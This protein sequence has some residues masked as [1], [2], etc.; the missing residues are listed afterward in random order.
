MCECGNIC[1]VSRSCFGYTRSCGCY[2][3]E[4]RDRPKLKSGAEALHY[5]D[6]R[7]KEKLYNVWQTMKART[8]NPNNKSYKDYGKRGIV[9]CVEWLDYAVFRDW[10]NR[11]GY[12][13]K[14]TIERKDVNGNYEPS[15]CCFIPRRKQHYNKTNTVFVEY[16]GEIKSLSEW[17]DIL[18]LSH[19]EHSQKVRNRWKKTG[20]RELIL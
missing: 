15:N 17:C 8:S 9:V 2:F 11:N 16:N 5:K 14:M 12:E 1:I 18:G 4:V 13:D 20:K 19:R 3:E 10:A 6:G 7:C